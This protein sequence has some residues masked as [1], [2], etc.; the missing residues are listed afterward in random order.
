MILVT[1]VFVEPAV[2]ALFRSTLGIL[3]T[4]L[5]Y[6]LILDSVSFSPNPT[7]ALVPLS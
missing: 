2:F 3:G 1:I 4:I 5:I 6:P 7:Q